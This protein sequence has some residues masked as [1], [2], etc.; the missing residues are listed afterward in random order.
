ML[1]TQLHPIWVK[2]PVKHSKM[3]SFLGIRFVEKELIPKLYA[4][5]KPLDENEP[6][7]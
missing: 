3:L 1:L 4:N 2:E 6:Q 7:W 5:M